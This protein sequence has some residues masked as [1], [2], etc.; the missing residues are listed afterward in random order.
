MTVYKYFIKIT[1]K[2]KK[3]ILSYVLLFLILAMINGS[4]TNP[5]ETTFKEAKLNIGIINNSESEL[6]KSLIKYLE[7]K[8]DIVDTV[9]DEDYIKEQIFLE[10]ADA[11]IIIP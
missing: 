2:N 11:V 9:N 10:V 4:N 7:E 3:I 1:L 6:S 8:N 5:G